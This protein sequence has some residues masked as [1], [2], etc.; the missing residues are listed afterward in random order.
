MFSKRENRAIRMSYVFLKGL[1]PQSVG[2]TGIW[3]PSAQRHPAEPLALCCWSLCDGPV[4]PSKRMETV[5]R[6]CH[7]RPLR[8]S[9]QIRMTFRCRGYGLIFYDTTQVSSIECHPM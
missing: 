4:V 1:S 7:V 5:G 6:S 2:I 3:E 8:H 9:P